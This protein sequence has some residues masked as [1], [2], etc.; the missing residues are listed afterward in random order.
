MNRVKSSLTENV[1]QTLCWFD[2]FGQAASL[3]E[4]HRFLF[5]QKASEKEVERVLKKDPRIG[6][7]FGFY[8]LRRKNAS[9]LAR[10]G[11]QFQSGKL[12]RRVLRHLFLFRL[13]PFL[14]L[15]AVGN[16]LAMGWPEKNSD[17][18]L[19]IIAQKNRLFTARFFLTLWTQIFRMRR[20]GHK[21]SGRF[22]LSFFLAKDSLDLEKLK[23][24]A[25]DPYLA[26][27][28]TTLIP[29]Y[30]D[31]ADFFAANTWVQQY[32]P[33][34]KLA[35]TAKKIRGKTLLE[36]MLSG[37]VGNGLERSLQKWQ[38]KRATK[39]QKSKR[40]NTVVISDEVLKFHETDRREYF[41]REWRKR[42]SA[43]SKAKK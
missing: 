1:W 24:G 8:F 39:K 41:L 18:D 34:A 4:I 42:V 26:F 28:V 23:I 31:S 19:L 5:W 14:R 30:G 29:L 36:K 20:H 27:W 2:V 6:S 12:W 11:R 43:G 35:T 13:T 32:F 37:H 33:N 38:L 25:H 15:A 17:I 10:C 9:V 40:K 21:I 22:C 7:S 3:E 16:T